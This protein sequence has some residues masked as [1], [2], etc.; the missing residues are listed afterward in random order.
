MNRLLII[1]LTLLATG[2]ALI[3]QTPNA[4]EMFRQKKTQRKYSA[5]QVIALKA[6]LEVLKKGYGIVQKG[7]D[8][9]GTSK[10][11]TYL[12][13]QQYFNSLKEVSAVVRKS[14]RI[15][16]IY[17]CQQQIRQDFLMLNNDC[18]ADKNFTIAEKNYIEKVYLNMIRECERSLDQL[19][20]AATSSTGMTDADRLQRLDRISEDMKD[21]LA[22]TRDFI[23]STRGLSL[24]RA[25][26]KRQIETVKKLYGNP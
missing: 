19:V 26:E 14:P 15:S 25:K 5:D 24:A 8:E 18:H 20:F 7:L 13:D 9:V 17:I 6:Y 23:G 12:R 2:S 16:E 22:F 4:N 21:K 11:G 1:S 3:A 10:N